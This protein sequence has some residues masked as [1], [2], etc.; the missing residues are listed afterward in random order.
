MAMKEYSAF[1]K[2]LVWMD[3]HH[4]IVKCYIQDTRWLSHTPLQRCNRCIQQLH[5][6]DWA[7]LDRRSFVWT[8]ISRTLVRGGLTLC[9]DAVGIFL[10]PQLNGLYIIIIFSCHQHG[11]PWPFLATP[12]YRSSLPA[13]PQGYTLYPH[14]VA[15]CMF[16]LV[17]LL[18]L[19]HVKGSIRVHHLWARLYFSRSVLHVWF[20]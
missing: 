7:K 4:Q 16:E 8:H 10:Q 13:G 6:A 15:V 3:P 12:P 14:R 11:Y 17:A 20:V 2:A 5:P 19:G 18:L 9:R 1:P